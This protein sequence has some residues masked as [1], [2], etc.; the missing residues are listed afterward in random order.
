MAKELVLGVET[1]CDETAVAVVAQGRQILSNVI[2]TQIAIHQKFGG[3]VPEIASRK[4]VETILPVLEEALQ[5][6]GIHF[7]DL[8]GV[9]VTNGPGL[10]GG[11]LVGL[12]AAKALAYGAGLPLIG[13]NH[14]EGHIHANILAHHDLEPPFICLIVSGG[15]SDLVIVRD[16]GRYEI[17]GRTRDDAAGE[18]FDKV[19]KFLGLGYPGGPLIDVLS[20]KGDPTAVDFPR[21][22]LN[23]PNFD[24]SF[25]G[26]KTAVINHIHNLEQR[27]KEIAIAHIAASFQRAVVHVLVAKTLAAANAYGMKQVVL[28]GGVA[29]NSELRKTLESQGRAHGYQVYYPPLE[30][31]TDNGAMIA[32]AGYFRLKRGETSP[33]DLNVV[34][35]LRLGN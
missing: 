16:F 27:G 2:S 32:S 12:T 7:G 25:S 1:S 21:A 20:R 24:F 17:L 26:L 4:H 8:W 5:Q 34:P 10:V 22:M 23:E 18:A 13:V 15:H 3:V 19:A 33:W 35:G 14:V 11:L 28:S 29:A 30:L 9:S 31:C 6:A